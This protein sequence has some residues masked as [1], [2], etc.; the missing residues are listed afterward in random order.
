MLNNRSGIRARRKVSRGVQ[1]AKNLHPHPPHPYRYF[2]STH[3]SP[4]HPLTIFA[5][6][7]PV[8][9]TSVGCSDGNVSCRPVQHTFCHHWLGAI[10]TRYSVIFSSCDSHGVNQV[11]QNLLPVIS[12]LVHSQ[13]TQHST[14]HS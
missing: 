3:P 11:S 1:M 10:G 5:H 9:P 12:H 2:C 4:T 13:P 14:Q 6:S 7:H 8:P